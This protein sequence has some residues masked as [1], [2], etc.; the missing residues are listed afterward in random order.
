MTYNMLQDIFINRKKELNEIPHG[1][2]LG[3][4]F[5]LIAP[6]R[7]GKTTLIKKIAQ[8]M[9]N[10]KVIYIDV[11]RFSYSLIAL[12]E[13]IVDNCLAQIGLAGRFKNWVSNIN[14]KLDIK[15]KIQELELEAIIDKIDK[16]DAYS[17]FAEALELPEKLARKYNQKWLVI[18]DEIGELLNLGIAAIK[19]MRSVIQHH[20][21]AN[22]IF[23]GSQETVMNEIFV[24]KLGA[25]YRFGI[26]YELTELDINDVTAFFKDDVKNIRQDV[27]DYISEQFNGH[28][29]YTTNIFYRISMLIKQQPDLVIDFRVIRQIFDELLFAENHYLEDQVQNLAK[30]KHNIPV[31]IA[32]IGG[33]PYN[34]SISRQATYAALK[35]LIRDGYIRKVHGKYQLT[36]PL[37]KTYL[38]AD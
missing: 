9:V 6:R 28:P 36:D 19:T 12:T 23:A 29:Y 21:L 8:E 15:V 17:A 2:D 26:I 10:S 16:K 1:L 33:N 5:I 4:N 11:M 13:V 18:Y 24:N 32:A 38:N 27:I 35:N 25:F 34:A 22:Y 7:Y 30:G 14:L 20:K 31:I 37:L 3:Q